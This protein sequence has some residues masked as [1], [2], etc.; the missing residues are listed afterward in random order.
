MKFVTV[1]GRTIN[2]DQV[3]YVEKDGNDV[4]IFFAVS[5][6]TSLAY[7]KLQGADGE[8]FLSNLKSLTQQW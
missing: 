4:V 7:I 2:L 1:A 5:G 6:R 8:R 3:A